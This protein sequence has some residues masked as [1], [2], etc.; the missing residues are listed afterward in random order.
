MDNN[1][2]TVALS[3]S[4]IKTLQTCSWLYHCN[5]EIKLPQG[6]NDGARRGSCVHEILELLTKNRHKKYIDLIAS[7]EQPCEVKA[8]EKLMTAKFKKLELEKV[9]PVKP[10]S[11]KVSNETNWDCVWNMLKFTIQKEY[12]DIGDKKIIHSEYEFDMENESPRYKVRGFIDRLSEEDGVIEILDFKG[13]A[14]KFKGDE[15]SSNVQ[16]MIYSLVAR[17]IWKHYKRYRAN[18]FFMRFKKDPYQCNEFSDEE[19]K[20]FESY[21][22]YVTEIIE[23]FDSKTAVSNM[24]SESKEKSWLCGR[25]KWQCPYKK[26]FFFFV[27]EDEAGKQLSSHLS[28]KEAEEAALKIKDKKVNIEMKHYHGCPSWKTLDSDENPF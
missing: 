13:S 7:A 1:K 27:V 10:L 5:Y 3:A 28:H 18:F 4:K 9:E 24:A 6:S 26:P 22:E 11:G 12:L 15:E 2:P 20:G 25:G 17:K 19:L 16:A 8:I 23:N 14:R 21:L